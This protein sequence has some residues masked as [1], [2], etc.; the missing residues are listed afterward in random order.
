MMEI[1]VISNI[2][3]CNYV[4]RSTHY[5]IYSYTVRLVFI[6]REIYALSN[7][8]SGMYSTFI[9]SQL[10]GSNYMISQ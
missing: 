2:R 8:S 1:S 10:V 9:D 7:L 6:W 5:Q 4:I 3:G